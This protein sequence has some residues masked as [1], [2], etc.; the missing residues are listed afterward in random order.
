MLSILAILASLALRMS[1]AVAA[2]SFALTATGRDFVGRV[3]NGAGS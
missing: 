2:S 3:P 1:A